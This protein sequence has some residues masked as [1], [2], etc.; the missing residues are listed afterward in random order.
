EDEVKETH[1]HQVLQHILSVTT[2]LSYR[3]LV[4][5]G[6]DEVVDLVCN[7]NYL[8]IL[9]QLA[10]YDTFLDEHIPKHANE[11]K[12]HVSYISSAVC[13]EFTEILQKEV[14]IAIIQEIKTSKYFSVSFHST[15]EISHMNQLTII[16]RYVLDDGPV[17]RFATFLPVS[18]HI[19]AEFARVLINFFE[20]NDIR[21]QN[22]H[23]QS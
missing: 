13:D 9:V 19:E 18:N 2:F 5:R 4:F 6:S 23:E 7:R 21:I 1:W 8:G 12:D 11:G 15:P 16:F 3:G 14:L 22:L 20:K 10:E 17:E